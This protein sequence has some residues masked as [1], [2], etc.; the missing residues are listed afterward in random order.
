MRKF[1]HA[2][3]DGRIF[4]AMLSA[5]VQGQQFEITMGI[6]AGAEPVSIADMNERLY[7]LLQDHVRALFGEGT[8]RAV[9]ADRYE[10]A[11][12]DGNTT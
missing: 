8:L 10:F 9:G 2:A 4:E 5:V 12:S 11:K 3:A 6:R 1:V 7:S